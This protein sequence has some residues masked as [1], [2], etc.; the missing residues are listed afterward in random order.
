MPQRL[1]ESS[2]AQNTLTF[3]DS[4]QKR[5]D[6]QQRRGAEACFPVPLVIK[7]NPKKNVRYSCRFR[8]SCEF[9]NSFDVLLTGQGTYEEHEHKPLSPAPRTA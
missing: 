2:W 6:A 4:L 8:F 5:H 7:F 1:V 9:G 3:R